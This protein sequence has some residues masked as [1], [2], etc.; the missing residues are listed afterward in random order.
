M[1]STDL[2]NTEQTISMEPVQKNIEVLMFQ[3]HTVDGNF[4]I[5]Y[6]ANGTAASAQDTLLLFRLVMYQ[7]I[8]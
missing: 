2:Q 7:R 4:I 8:P 3:D 1:D 5:S 6:G